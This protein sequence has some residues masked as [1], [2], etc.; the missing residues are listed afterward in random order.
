MITLQRFP[1][2]IYLL[3]LSAVARCP[4]EKIKRILFTGN[5]LILS[6]TSVNLSYA[7]QTEKLFL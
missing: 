2:Y 5:D 3:P 6:T 7:E 1:D 4:S